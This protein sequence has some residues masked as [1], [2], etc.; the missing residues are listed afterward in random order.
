MKS[1]KDLIKELEKYPDD[2]KW[3]AIIDE[4]EGAMLITDYTGNLSNAQAAINLD[5]PANIID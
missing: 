5:N 2:Y 3:Y 4:D 1:T